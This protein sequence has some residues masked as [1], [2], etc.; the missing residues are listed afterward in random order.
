VGGWRLFRAVLAWVLALL[1]TAGIASAARITYTVE[2]T[3]AYAYHEVSTDQG[4]TTLTTDES[5]RWTYKGTGTVDTR[6][7]PVT[8]TV[9]HGTLGLSG[10][11]DQQ[12][13]TNP[14]TDE[15]CTLSA[16]DISR[17]LVTLTVGS[18]GVT[19]GVGTDVPDTYIKAT[20]NRENCN[21][22]PGGH[23]LLC[24][25]E[26]CGSDCGPPPSGA[27]SA[28][29]VWSPVI[30][31]TSF[32]ERVGLRRQ[33]DLPPADQTVN[34]TCFNGTAG[35]QTSLKIVSTLSIG[36]D[37][38]NADFL[39]RFPDGVPPE[40]AKPADLLQPTPSGPGAPTIGV[41][42]TIPQPPD[43]TPGGQ[44]LLGGVSLQCPKADPSCPTTVTVQPAGGGGV[45]ARGRFS[46]PRGFGALIGLKLPRAVGTTLKRAERLRVRV[47][48]VVSV[49]D[50]GTYRARRT[51]T[52]LAS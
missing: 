13:P 27:S 47:G 26:F 34:T 17:P 19:P 38:P 1:A 7:V 37:W 8:D 6:H 44:P 43:E 36:M 49:P 4:Q 28:S 23:G 16:A 15:H 39:L 20:G 52:L 5:M 40:I 46:V 30:K 12:S 41:P 11:L 25:P 14:V 31:P 18:D 10:V 29:P 9:L 35:K 21:I 3:G 22:R 45:L 48:V 32:G 24:N 50:G 2:Y 42:P 51:V 33:F